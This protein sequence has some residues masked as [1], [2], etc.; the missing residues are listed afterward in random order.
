MTTM[1]MT[2]GNHNQRMTSKVS[3]LLLACVTLVVVVNLSADAHNLPKLSELLASTGLQDVEQSADRLS[4]KQQ[5]LIKEIMDFY[6]R[7]DNLHDDERALLAEVG[8]TLPDMEQK[9]QLQQMFLGHFE[10]WRKLNKLTKELTKENDRLKAEA[11][12]KNVD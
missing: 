11:S 8:T 6:E 4:D 7:D 3:V 9:T 5:A 2:R 10:N 1:K 12:T